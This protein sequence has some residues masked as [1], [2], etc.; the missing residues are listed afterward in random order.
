[1]INIFLFEGH[2]GKDPELKKSTDG[3]SYCTFTMAQTVKRKKQGEDKE[4]TMWAEVTI[5][6]KI[7]ENHAK[8]LHK[9]RRVI[10][11]GSMFIEDWTDRDNRARYTMKIKALEVNYAD[12]PTRRGGEAAQE[13]SSPGAASSL[14]NYDEEKPLTGGDD[15]PTPW[16]K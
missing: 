6:G 13:E 14:D 3:T 5:W 11:N 7:A 10:V 4:H 15:T 2:L 16:S 9:G 12:E 1:M 8:N